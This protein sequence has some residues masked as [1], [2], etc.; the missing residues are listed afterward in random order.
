MQKTE[1]TDAA[2]VE[3]VDVDVSK[4]VDAL[5]DHG[6]AS[7]EVAIQ[8]TAVWPTDEAGQRSRRFY[9]E[10]IEPKLTAA[11]YTMG[12]ESAR[13][14][15]AVVDTFG[16]DLMVEVDRYGWTQVNEATRGGNRGNAEGARNVLKASLLDS[17]G[18]PKVDGNGDPVTRPTV[19]MV[20]ATA[21]DLAVPD[22]NGKAKAKSR[23][24]P[25]TV[26]NLTQAEI[27]QHDTESVT[28][29][30]DKLATQLK[31]ADNV[32][33]GRAPKENAA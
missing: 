9:E 17:K 30:R 8:L 22:G 27:R 1:N 10:S 11:G 5:R 18:N 24:K 6:K 3:T 31:R 23:P 20:K 21:R 15:A 13:A 12:W 7:A 4:L 19:A 33:R 16:D 32:L 14:Y 25:L 2:T 26:A 29:Y 28:A